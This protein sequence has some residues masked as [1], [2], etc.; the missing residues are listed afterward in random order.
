MPP[1]P[2]QAESLT[3]LRARYPAAL[4]HVYDVE[5]IRRGAVRP[6]EVSANVFDAEDGLRLIVSRERYPD[7]ETFLHFSA[8]FPAQC[9][10]ADELRRQAAISGLDRDEI[11]ERWLADVPRRFA[12]LSGDAR[13]PRFL[14]LSDHWIPHWIIED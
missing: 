10:M 14:G 12:E 4:E 6:G 2:H 11:L 7:D 13:P 8:S 1:V 9:R 5:A 3:A